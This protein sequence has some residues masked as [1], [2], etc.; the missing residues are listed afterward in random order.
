MRFVIFALLGM[1][2]AVCGASVATA[3]VQLTVT[4]PNFSEGRLIGVAQIANDLGCRGNNLS[5]AISW[6]EGPYGTRYYAV[7]MF[8]LDE[9]GFMEKGEKGFWH[10]HVLNIPADVTNLI[11]GAGKNGAPLPEG[12]SL[13]VNSMGDLGYFGPC[14]P[15]ADKPHR[16]VVQVYA[17]SAKIP[18]SASTPP[19][20]VEKALKPLML[21][22][23]TL[24]GIFG[25]DEASL[26]PVLS[27]SDLVPVKESSPL[28]GA[29]TEPAS[30][31]KGH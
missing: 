19:D 17:L 24:T 5:P 4:S 18:L 9:E 15:R 3:Q 1:V 12:A 22:S 16:Y 29:N 10:W 26:R 13:T 8:D 20:L 6:S 2:C 14:P 21:A 27:P 25:R 30:G 23:G 31:P 11:A 7:S 28:F